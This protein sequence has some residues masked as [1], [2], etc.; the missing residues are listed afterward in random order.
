[1][2]SFFSPKDQVLIFP[3]FCSFFPLLS[4]AFIQYFVSLQSNEEHERKSVTKLLAKMFSEPHSDL[5]LKNKPLWNCFL[6]RS[7]QQHF[8]VLIHAAQESGK[9]FC[10]C[11][12]WG[13]CLWGE[14][15]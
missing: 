12:Q 5:A 8:Y 14:C 6:G 10:T 11:H 7:E 2:L 15:C 3:L 13:I 9:G 4:H 1:M